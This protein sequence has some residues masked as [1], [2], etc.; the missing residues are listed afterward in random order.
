LAFG[1]T[2][3]VVTAVAAFAIIPWNFRDNSIPQSKPEVHGTPQASV[4]EAFHFSMPAQVEN[5]SFLVDSE[6]GSDAPT[7]LYLRFHTT[8]SGMK[9]FLASMERSTDDLTA[10]PRAAEL[11][12]DQELLDAANLNW[13]INDKGDLRG[14]YVDN[15]PGLHPGE[16]RSVSVTIDMTDSRTPLVY[17]YAE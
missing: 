6:D 11:P 10:A 15:I 4:Q 1:A 8:A 3:L 7:D 9:S 5:A 12:V 13:K 16:R 2:V 17:V 14:L